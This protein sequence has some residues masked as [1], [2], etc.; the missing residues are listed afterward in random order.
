MRLVDKHICGS[1]RLFLVLFFLAN[2]GFT[3]VLYRCTMTQCAMTDSVSGMACCAK[4]GMDCCTAGSCEGV[5]APQVAV[6]D[7][8]T[9][10]QPCETA[11]VVG[12]YQTDPTVVEKQ[13]DGRQIFTV[14]LLPTSAFEGG[15][16]PRADLPAFHF[17]STASNVSPPSVETYVLNASFL[18]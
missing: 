4:V 17:T 1:T 9:M 16:G 7:A 12:G 14:D 18:I 11:T 2:S 13:F 6:A 5:A 3:V 10:D 15:I 8:V